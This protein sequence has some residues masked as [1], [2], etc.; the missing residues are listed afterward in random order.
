MRTFW[1]I[2]L[3]LSGVGA[4]TGTALADKFQAHLT[5]EQLKTNCINSGGYYD[6][7]TA[8]GGYSCKLTHETFDCT[9]AGVCTITTTMVLTKPTK[10]HGPVSAQAP[11][12]TLN[13][14]AKMPS[15]GSA[16]SANSS[17]AVGGLSTSRPAA[18]KNVSGISTGN[19]GTTVGSGG[20]LFSH[21]RP[22]F[23]P[24]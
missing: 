19:S 20:S 4:L 22:N 5:R 3:G 1:I 21:D 7:D 18:M 9:A 15:S 17:F 13:G 2:V 12:A 16:P 11:A 14:N 8:K 23:R 6:P 24:Q 10:N